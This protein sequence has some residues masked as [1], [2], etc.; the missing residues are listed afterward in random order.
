MLHHCTELVCA[1]Q[2]TFNLAGAAT[3]LQTK[4][5]VL[6]G[7]ISDRACLVC[8]QVGTKT[9]ETLH[10]QTKQLERVVDDL[11]QIQF[12]LKKAQQVIRDITRGIATDKWVPGLRVL[13]L[14]DFTSSAG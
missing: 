13:G 11:D 7:I 5:L 10:D 12:S 1:L 9:A 2:A 4:H 6:A 14:A 3:Y 8:P